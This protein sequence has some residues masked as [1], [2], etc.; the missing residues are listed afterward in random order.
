MYGRPAFGLDVADDLYHV[1]AH[2]GF[3]AGNLHD[4]GP[5]HFHVTAVVGRFQIAR[6]VL[7]AAVIAVLAIAGAGIG[8]FER[9]DDGPPGKPVARTASDDLEGLR[10]WNFAHSCG[11]NG[12]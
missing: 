8:H 6:I 1:V 10:E 7:R 5:Q 3:T 2:Q 11:R 12:D 4:A 9:N